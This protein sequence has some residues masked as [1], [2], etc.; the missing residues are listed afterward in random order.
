[1]ALSRARV[2][3]GDPDLGAR[4]EAAIGAVLTAPH[5]PDKLLI[6][7]AE[8]R[9]RIEREHPAKTIW[10]VKFLRGGLTDLEFLAQYLLLRHA[11]EHPEVIDASTQAVYAKLAETGL[12]GPSLARRLIAATRLIRQVQ[13]MLRLTAAPAFDADSG[14]EGLQASLARAAGMADFAHLRA[15]LIATAAEVHEVFI[16]RIE[17][18]AKA[19]GAE[20]GAAK[21]KP[22]ADASAAASIARSGPSDQTDE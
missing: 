10:S 3:A 12:L 7:V 1:M 14:T 6:D 22:G 13:G 17:A 15:T 16:D 21:D 20:L 2:V 8:M 11:H 4:I 5:D 18:P 19:L 9:A